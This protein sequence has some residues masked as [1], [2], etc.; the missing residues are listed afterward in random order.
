MRYWVLMAM[1]LLFASVACDDPTPPD[2]LGPDDAGHQIPDGGTDEPSWAPW[3]PESGDA[4]FGLVW[5]I[6]AKAPG[7]DSC[8][9]VELARVTLSFVHSVVDTK[10]WTTPKL[11]SNCS[12]GEIRV[13][14]AAGFM[15]GKYRFEVL[16][17]K[18]DGQSFTHKPSGEVTLVSDE[19]TRI[20]I[21]DIAGATQPD[22]GISEPSNETLEGKALDAYILDNPYAK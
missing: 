16:L 15:P 11:S 19:V 3:P 10:I 2:L 17:E 1:L 5:M 13:E 9:A 7:S 20:A 14:P 6:D 8:A 4:G 21:I 18:P 22:A 12:A